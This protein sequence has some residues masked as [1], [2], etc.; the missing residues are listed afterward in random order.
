MRQDRAVLRTSGVLQTTGV[1]HATDCD[2][3]HDRADGMGRGAGMR[4]P[5]HLGCGARCNG[6]G[7]S[8]GYRGGR[9]FRTPSL[10]SGEQINGTDP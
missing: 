5:Q 3:V 8:N 9:L 1:R 7:R 10:A 6:N 2:G 4:R